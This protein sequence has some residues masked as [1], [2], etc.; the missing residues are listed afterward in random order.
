MPDWKKPLL[1]TGSLAVMV[2]LGAGGYS[3]IPAPVVMPSPLPPPPRDALRFDNGTRDCEQFCPRMVLIPKGA[4]VMGI[5]DA[6]TRREADADKTNRAWIELWDKDAKPPHSVTI[7]QEFYLSETPV[8]RGEYALC[9]QDRQCDSVPEPSFKEK[10]GDTD[11]VVNVSWDDTQKYV[12][13]LSGKAGKTYRLPT[14]AEWEYAAR[15]VTSV[16]M[17]SYARYWGDGFDTGATVP[18]NR[19]GTMPVKQ[20]KA[21]AFGLYDVLGHV[22]QWT[23][24][25]WEDRYKD[26]KPLDETAN[27]AGDCGRRVLRG[28][29]WSFSPRVVRAGSRVRDDFGDRVANTGF[30]VARTYLS[31]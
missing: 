16:S 23:E 12:K 27:T 5:P 2:A 28:G 10:P 15:G 14:E 25:C 19:G 4:F 11:P 6:E 21:N 13:W 20:F 7:R 3:L 30:R 9:V 17:P 8:T 22:W 18:R 24:D 26:N 31:P 1:L 29:S